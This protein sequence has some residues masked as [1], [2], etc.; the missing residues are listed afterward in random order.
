[1]HIVVIAKTI[2]GRIIAGYSK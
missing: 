1:M 2:Y